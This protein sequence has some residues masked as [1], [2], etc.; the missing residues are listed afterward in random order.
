MVAD[1]QLELTNMLVITHLSTSF[2]QHPWRLWEPLR[3]AVVSGIGELR[4]HLTCLF[5]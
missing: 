3:I 1:H 4:M 5:P 2:S